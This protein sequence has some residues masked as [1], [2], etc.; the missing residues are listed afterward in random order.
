VKAAKP[1]LD[2]LT[3]ARGLAAWFVVLYHIRTGFTDAV[4]QSLIKVFGQ[5]YL[6]VDLFFV[7]SGFVMWLNYGEKFARDG[8]RAAPDFLLR[9]IARIYP[10][11]FVILMAMIVFAML[12]ASTGRYNA[13][14]Y[15][16]AELP[17]HF[18]LIQNWGLTDGLTWN[19]PAWSI[20][21]EFGAYLILPVAALGFA[22]R[23]LSI[24]AIL[25]VIAALCLC[26]SAIIYARGAATIGHGIASN[27]LI[28]CV[29]EFFVGVFVC[30]L[31]QQSSAVQHRNLDF[32]SV[33]L[34]VALIGAVI[35][36]WI[37]MIFAVPPIFAASVYLLARS[38]AWP[39]NPLASGALV[40]VG[41]IS[42][43]T[44]LVHF[45]LWVLFKLMFVDDQLNVPLVLMVAFLV[46][47]LVLSALLYH[48]VEQPGRKLVQRIFAHRTGNGRAVA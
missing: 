30:M 7:L 29:F 23:Q 20:S 11:H 31:W 12:I 32:A 8:L 33:T 28:R 43:S 13:E 42:Y 22:R 38:S 2:A 19:D 46:L 9:R 3:G 39:A 24:G 35:M 41:E 4:P 15:P 17:L 27:G 10:L 21:T 44:Y 36:G 45:F 16:W 34:I 37:N 14:H 1:Q 47:T 48:L 26:V 6:A 40:Y 18:L 5:G 25:T